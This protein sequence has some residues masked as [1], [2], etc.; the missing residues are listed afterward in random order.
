MNGAQRKQVER[1]NRSAVRIVLLYASDYALYHTYAVLCMIVCSGKL[2]S[3]LLGHT[4]VLLYCFEALLYGWQI[5]AE[6]TQIANVHSCMIKG[7]R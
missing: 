5:S 7:Q 6:L 1:E 3:E 2:K 4:L